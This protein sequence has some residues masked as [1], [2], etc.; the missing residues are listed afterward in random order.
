MQ[1]NEKYLFS[2]VIAVYN[3]EEYLEETVQSLINQTIGFEK[4][5]LILVDDGSVDQSALICDRYAAQYSNVVALHRQNA[6][7]SAAR[8]LGLAYIQGKYVNFLDSDDKLSHNAMEEAAAFFAEYQDQTDVVSMPMVFFDGQTGQHIL[9]YK[10]KKGTRLIDLKTEYNAIQLSMSS[11]FVCAEALQGKKFDTRLAYAEDAKLM[12]SILVEKQTLGVI[13]KATYY[14][15]RHSIGAGS[16]IQTSTQRKAWY[17]PYMTYF[18]H[19]V[20]NWFVAKEIEIPKFI[21]FTL[22]YDLQWRIRMS[23]IPIG[24][25]SGLEE[26]EYKKLVEEMFHYFDDDVILAQKNIGKAYKLYIL[27]EKYGHLA[28]RI[29]DGE[30]I[31]LTYGNRIITWLSSSPCKLEFLTLKKDRCVLEGTYEMYEPIGPESGFQVRF[32]DTFFTAEV[33]ADR[34]PVCSLGTEIMYQLCFRV[35]LPLEQAMQPRQIHFYYVWNGNRVHCNALRYGKFFPLTGAYAN[36]YVVEN[37]WKLTKGKNCLHIALV[38][39]KEHLHCE[40]R[41]LKELWKKNKEGARKA[42]VSRIV[43]FAIKAVYKKPIW[44]ISDRV[45]KADDNGEALFGYIQKE[46]RNNVSA[47]FVL[48]KSSPDYNRMKEVGPVLN[49]FSHKDKFFVT[50]ADCIISTQAE[51]EVRNPFGNYADAYKDILYKIPFVFLQHGIT[52]DD[53]SAWLG[54]PNKNF[55]GLVTAAHPEYDSIINGAYH[56]SEDQVWLTG[57]P[58]YDRLHRA[59]NHIITIMPTWR[60]YLLGHWSPETDIW[61]LV[62]EFEESDYYRFYNGLLNSKKLLEAARKHGYTIQFL[63]HPTIQPHIDI[64]TQSE[65]VKFLGRDKHYRDVYAESNLVVTD[66]SSAV[67]DFAYLEKPVIYCQFDAETFFAGEHAYTKG[68]YDYERDGFGEVE[69]DL[70]H[71]VDRIIE[72][73]ENGCQMKEKYKKRGENFFAYHDKNNCQRVY[74]RITQML[75]E[76]NG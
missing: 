11:T 32:G 4:I 40:Y 49:W 21:Q 1:E 29:F 36:S 7:V 54:R 25:L 12:Q 27:R 24:V 47:F 10:F 45:T 43:R 5:Q 30:N 38:G 22:L 44:L 31:C 52:K 23:K 55:S 3:A 15:R 69:Y 70:E 2:V 20:L 26:Q 39:R 65:G 67:F 37:S 16:A 64:F 59:E 58:R 68:Y 34:K 13:P 8:N 46:Q 71:T 76:R 75:A 42:V 41:L 60:R 50:V 73:M 18:Q 14:Y 17:L 63:P 66:Y 51:D 74:E 53:V 48:S 28:G 33:S 6:G 35:E 57:F 9:N 19:E 72:Y 56:Y 62:P 61:S